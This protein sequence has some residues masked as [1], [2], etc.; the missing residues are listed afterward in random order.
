MLLLLVDF[1]FL[2]R[3]EWVGSV[4]ER[5][6][7]TASDDSWKL[8][9]WYHFVWLLHPINLK[10]NENR[11][12]RHVLNLWVSK[13]KRYLPSTVIRLSVDCRRRSSSFLV[14][15]CWSKWPMKN[16]RRR[17][18][19]HLHHFGQPF[20]IAL[21]NS[22]SFCRCVCWIRLKRLLTWKMVCCWFSHLTNNLRGSF[23]VVSLL[24]FYLIASM[25]RLAQTNRRQ[26]LERQPDKPA[27]N[28]FNLKML[29]EL[30]ANTC[31]LRRTIGSAFFFFCSVKFLSTFTF[32]L[33]FLLLSFS[34][35]SYR[36]GCMVVTD[37][38]QTNV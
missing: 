22:K 27:Y 13:R 3:K 38:Y 10:I 15:R 23:S 11:C 20:R 4:A 2:C 5:Y 21:W 25:C 26:R 8:C 24:V 32:F 12:R 36:I 18:K 28:H 37:Q 14:F 29:L 30:W 34:F 31:S 35:I 1:S 17:L 7:S 9:A 33:F 16:V 19:S 6:S